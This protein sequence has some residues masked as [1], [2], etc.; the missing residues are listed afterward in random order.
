MSQRSHPKHDL[1]ER[2]VPRVSRLV[3]LVRVELVLGVL[4]DEVLGEGAKAVLVLPFIRKLRVRLR[5]MHCRVELLSLTVQQITIVLTCSRVVGSCG[6]DTGLK[7]H[8]IGG[9]GLGEVETCSVAQAVGI[10]GWGRVRDTARGSAVSVAETM[11]L[12]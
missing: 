2:L 3:S 11:S 5:I 4:H 8:V 10:V 6:I 9:P 7:P 1:V 12:L